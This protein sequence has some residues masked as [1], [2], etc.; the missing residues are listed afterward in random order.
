MPAI[1]TAPPIQIDLTE[2]SRQSSAEINPMGPFLHET[3]L[4]L[5]LITQESARVFAGIY[6][7]TDEGSTWVLQDTLNKPAANGSAI[8][9]SY[10]PISGIIG[11]VSASNS[12]AFSWLWFPFNTN[13]DTY[14]T[15]VQ[16]L[17]FTPGINDS[18]AFTYRQLNT[19]NPFV[20]IETTTLKVLLE[21]GGAWTGPTSIHNYGAARYIIA[22]ISDSADRGHFIYIDNSSNVFYNQLSSSFALGTEVAFTTPADNKTG[23]MRVWNGKI[24]A[25]YTA[26]HSVLVEIG[27]GLTDPV[28]FTEFVIATVVAP[29]NVSYARLSEDKDGN[30]V[31]FWTEVDY[32]TSPVV[33]RE[34]MSTFDGISAWGAPVLFYDE[35]D[36][37][38]ANSVADVSQFIHT[39]QYLQLSDGTWL[40]S[41]ALEILDSHD[42]QQCTGFIL[43]S[44]P[45]AP[46]SL[47]CPVVNTGVVGVPFDSFMIASGGTTPYTF[48]IIGGSLP[49]G[50]T[51]NTTTGEISGVPT[52]PGTYTYT[53]SV[54]GS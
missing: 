4:Y 18:G 38:P 37:P 45:T 54:V 5:A 27:D 7:S 22:G 28:T 34:W 52:T 32:S 13:T 53:V 51:L 36:N 11:V 9:V 42:A 29:A 40:G 1:I 43:K 35:M 39:G 19:D 10:D 47:A 49:P 48:T 30:L 25:A 12:P 20:Y 14:G 21:T 16:K 6:K 41:I 31:V 26:T 46:L 23:D 24:V 15:V 8:W 17:L 44:A 2:F 50:L 33:D 3:D